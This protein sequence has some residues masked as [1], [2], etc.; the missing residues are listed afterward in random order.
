MPLDK[1][2]T[3]SSIICIFSK[4]AIYSHI[5]VVALFFT[6]KNSERDLKKK[7]Q[8]K[9]INQR[10]TTNDFWLQNFADKYL[11]GSEESLDERHKFC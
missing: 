3:I 2:Y 7:K 11:S 9:Q 5:A 6:A 8:L 10:I 4:K 1:F